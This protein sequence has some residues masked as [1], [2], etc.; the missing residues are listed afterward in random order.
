MVN[1]EIVGYGLQLVR[2]GP[3]GLLASRSAGHNSRQKS[4]RVM[5]T[6]VRIGLNIREL[7]GQTSTHMP[8]KLQREIS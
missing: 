7:A 8:Q 1:N 6:R 2:A 3:R 5:E 4:S